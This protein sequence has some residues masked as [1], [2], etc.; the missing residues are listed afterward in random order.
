VECHV[1]SVPK[2]KLHARVEIEVNGKDRWWA[3]NQYMCLGSG[4]CDG[5]EDGK[6]KAKE[7][8][9]QCVVVTPK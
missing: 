5:V 1:A 4:Q 7:A 8:F 9:E 6:K 2:T 3:F